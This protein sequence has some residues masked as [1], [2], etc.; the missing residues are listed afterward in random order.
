MHTLP[1]KSPISGT[2]MKYTTLESGLEAFHCTES[3]GYYIPA[4]AYLKWLQQQPSR[5]PHLP[6]PANA[7]EQV[8]EHLHALICPESG[9]LMSRFKVGH[10][11]SFSINRSI[12]GGIWLDQGE[13]EALRER[14]FHDEIHLVFTAPWQKQV[15]TA[16]AQALYEET[17]KSAL[18]AELLNRLIALRSELLDHQHKNLALS[19][20][21]EKANRL[22]QTDS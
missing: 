19:Y 11:F 1:L 13:W 4:P 14:N 9:T 5:L 17:L 20:L 22:E 21:M 8:H 18:G 15:R 2:L 7:N 3:G 10:G 12:T 16:R 6:K